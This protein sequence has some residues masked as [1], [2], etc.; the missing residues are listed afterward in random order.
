MVHLLFKR[1]FVA[2]QRKG[3]ERLMH[4]VAVTAILLLAEASTLTLSESL[5]LHSAFVFCR[6]R[7]GQALL[8]RTVY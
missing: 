7:S 4:R 1:A 2:T 6:I 8:L 3:G 5:S